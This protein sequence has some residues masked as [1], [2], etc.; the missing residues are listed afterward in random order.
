MTSKYRAYLR[1]QAQVL[2]PVVMVGKEGITENVVRALEDALDCHELVKV[3]FQNFKDET[4]ALSLDLEKKSDSTLVSVTGFTA[5][6]YRV[7][8]LL[9]EHRY[10]SLCQ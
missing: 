9:E 10:N 7:N 6:F 8:P 2:D 1:S 5:V 4:K 3:R